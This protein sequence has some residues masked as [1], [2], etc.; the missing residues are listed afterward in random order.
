MHA[1][2]WERSKSDNK[3]DRFTAKSMRKHVIWFEVSK[4]HAMHTHNDNNIHNCICMCVCVKGPS[5]ISQ[6]MKFSLNNQIKSNCI[7]NDSNIECAS[8][9]NPC[10]LYATQSIP[11]TLR[12]TNERNDSIEA[13]E[14]LDSGINHFYIVHNRNRYALIKVINKCM[15]NKKSSHCQPSR[16]ASQVD[17]LMLLLLFLHRFFRCSRNKKWKKTNREFNVNVM[18]KSNEG[19]QIQR[20]Y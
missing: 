13:V 2:D 17:A 1:I 11:C 8:E 7:G 15:R 20:S 19:K 6:W 10:H 3:F 12:T 16:P 9:I 14:S 4:P 5:A 18:W